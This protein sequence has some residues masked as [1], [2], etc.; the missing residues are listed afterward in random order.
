MMA[1]WTTSRM[2]FYGQW[3]HRTCLVPANLLALF[4]AAFF[5][6]PVTAFSA[7]PAGGPLQDSVALETAS[8]ET[9]LNTAPLSGMR[10]LPVDKA[11]PLK[12]PALQR[13]A[14]SSIGAKK[15]IVINIPARQLYLYHGPSLLKTYSV[16]VGRAGYPTPLGQFQVI[17]KVIDPGWENPYLGAGKVRIKPGNDNPLGTRWIGFKEDGKGEY[18]IHGTDTPP[19]VGKYSS[20]GCV[21]M[22]I[23]QA[24]E[25]FDLVDVGT[26]VK[27]VYE[28]VVISQKN[29]QIWVSVFP[30]AFGK[31]MPTLAALQAKILRDYPDGRVNPSQ[32]QQALK[33]PAQKPVLVGQIVQPPLP[34]VSNTLETKAVTT[35]TDTLSSEHSASVSQNN[36]SSSLKDH[37]HNTVDMFSLPLPQ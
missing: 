13:P 5:L 23:K 32:L 34:V 11:L 2:P 25:L 26:P 10:P 4:M 19:S 17:R 15:Q 3:K 20:H 12:S 16:G 36:F 28:P 37:D 21:R 31:G 1:N 22:Y 24:E 35:L 33:L 8:A 18:G 7:Q 6:M 14:L 9:V 27:V 29:Q 30:D